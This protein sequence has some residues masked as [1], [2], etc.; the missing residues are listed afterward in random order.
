MVIACLFTPCTILVISAQASLSSLLARD[1]RASILPHSDM[2]AVL[3]IRNDFFRIR[4][5]IWILLFSWFRILHEFLKNNINIHNINKFFSDSFRIRSC[6]DPKWFFPYPNPDPDPA[7]SF[8]SNRIR[9]HKNVCRDMHTLYSSV[10]G[11]Q[12]V[13]KYL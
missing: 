4:I 13:L 8:G 2:L 11:T 10:H 3:W 12:R 9:I 5:K 6:S 7:K 1:K